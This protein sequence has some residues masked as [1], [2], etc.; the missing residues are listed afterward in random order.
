MA[1]DTVIE[2][3]GLGTQQKTI[4]CSRLIRTGLN[5]AVLPDFEPHST[6]NELSDDK[7]QFFVILGR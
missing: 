4:S 3:I 1:K 6:E 2:K 7:L 5:N